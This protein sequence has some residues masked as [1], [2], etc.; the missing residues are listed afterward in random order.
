MI[1]Y[2]AD[3]SSWRSARLQWKACGQKGVYAGEM[4]SGPAIGD[5]SGPL[6][7]I[8][9]MNNFDRCVRARACVC[10]VCVSR[11]PPPSLIPH[12]NLNRVLLANRHIRAFNRSSGAL[13]WAYE[14][15]GP[16]GG[17]ATIVDSTVF[18]GSW[19]KNYYAINGADGSKRWCILFQTHGILLALVLTV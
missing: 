15:K 7:D 10:V 8:V 14:T 13:L 4:N 6:A 19:D 11:T 1:P 9:V 12:T 5:P 17:S 2:V 16:S 18:V 3:Q